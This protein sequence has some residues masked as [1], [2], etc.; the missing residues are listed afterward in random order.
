VEPPELETMKNKLYVGNLA[1]TTT[2]D[3]LKKAFGECGEVSEV[4]LMMDRETGRSRG[5]AFVLMSTGEQA[6]QA[7]ERWH[8]ATLDGRQLRVNEAEDR[9]S[10]FGG[11]DRGGRSRW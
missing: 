3:S 6:R 11:A 1:F 8:G 9:K 2:E 7:T 4:T 10:G 5:F